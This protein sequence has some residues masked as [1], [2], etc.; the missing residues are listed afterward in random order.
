MI[1]K[2]IYMC[3]K[4]LDDITNYSQNWQ[5]LNPEYEIKLYDD[6]LCVQFLL[7]HYS[8]LHASIFNYIKDG[9]IKC[10]FWRVCIINTFGGLYVD[11]D[12]EPLC[13]LREYIED[14]DNFVTCI[15]SSFENTK[16]EWNFNPHFIMSHK[17][18][19]IL[20]RCID[21]YIHYY[22]NKTPYTYWGWSVCKVF[23]VANVKEKKSQVIYV[24][25]QKHKLL[26]ELA[27]GNDCQ[28]NGTIVLHNR[29]SNYVNHNF[30]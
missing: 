6:A 22:H 1:P 23:C 27:N 19:Y 2:V 14:D 30:K 20:Q 16:S 18:N 5:I 25:G 13:P 15:S 26:L 9:P 10:D 29:Y 28:Y 3:H 7:H 17:N 11:A 21:Q 8:P 4:H 12:I 24:N